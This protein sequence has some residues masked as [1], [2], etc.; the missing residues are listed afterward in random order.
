[1]LSNSVLQ[2]A[3]DSGSDKIP[4]TVSGPHC[5]IGGGLLMYIPGIQ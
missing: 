2:L 4:I 1:M 5:G 3:L